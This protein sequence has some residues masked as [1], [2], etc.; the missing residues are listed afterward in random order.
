MEAQPRVLS[1]LI[2]SLGFHLGTA[3]ILAARFPLLGLPP[4]WLD[5]AL[6][7]VAAS[8]LL[9]CLPLLFRSR[10]V[11]AASFT[12]RILLYV[13]LALPLGAT[14]W[15]VLGLA[16]ALILDAGARL[17]PPAGT[18]LG[19]AVAALSLVRGIVPLRAWNQDVSGS[20]SPENLFGFFALVLVLVL[21]HSV[22]A[23]RNRA[24]KDAE[25]VR[26]LNDS[27]L[28]LTSA[29]QGFLNYA[30]E[31]ERTSILKERN[32]LTR[33]MHDTLS[34]TL[35][36]IRMM[37][38][39]ALRRDWEGEEL[40]KLHQWTRDQAQQGLQ[41][42]RSILYLIRSMAE[43]EIKGVREIQNLVQTFMGATRVEVIV[44]WGNIPWS[45][46]NDY[47]NITVF[48][49]IQESMTNA[50]RHGHATRIS[51][52]FFQDESALNIR[53]EDNGSGSSDFK[54]GIGLSGME[55]RLK[56]I[57][58]TITAC[59]TDSGFRLFARIPVGADLRVAEPG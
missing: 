32:R 22:S 35:T 41:E 11:L 6:F 52:Y 18:W 42:T 24:R 39:A 21:V 47:T 38:E 30:S 50:F 14:L 12:L 9:T 26:Q 34:H 58:G 45:W 19:G 29:N 43:P 40:R 15:L 59:S 20:L 36:N 37:M 27:I 7:S 25:L 28:A 44:D 2:L 3:F 16:F 8:A 5:E 13:L 57:E 55:E 53:I 56:P 49:I 54:K 23:L 46:Q 4:F 10:G 48:R 1:V 17:S 33:E 31:V 51:I